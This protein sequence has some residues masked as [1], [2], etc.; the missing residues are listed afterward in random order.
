MPSARLRLIVP[1]LAAA[2]LLAGCSGTPAASPSTLA[3]DDVQT[4]PAPEEEQA[5]AVDVFTVGSD[6]YTP[7]GLCTVVM[8]TGGLVMRAVEDENVQLSIQVS[9]DGTATAGIWTS[10]GQSVEAETG[11]WDVESLKYEG[12]ASTFQLT[13]D[14][15][16][17]GS[18]DLPDGAATTHVEV[19]A[20]C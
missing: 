16:L 3:G 20:A 14:G 9:G 2:G 17:V 15:R 4:A 5:A 6:S 1:V 10:P 12:S 19:D 7:D 18:G 11:R 8:G 13:G